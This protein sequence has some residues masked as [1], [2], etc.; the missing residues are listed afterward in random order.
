MKNIEIKSIKEGQSR[1]PKKQKNVFLEETQNPQKKRGICGIVI[2]TILI[3]FVIG[4]IAGILSDKFLA[5]YLE[6]IPQLRDYV[7][8]N[9]DG[10]IAIKREE[11]V[12]ITED[13]AIIDVVKQ[14]SP[15]VI[16]II[17]SKN[18]YDFFGTPYEQKSGGTGFIIT[19][20]GLIITNKHVV[21][22]QYA[23]YTVLTHNGQNFPTEILSLDPLTD[24]AIL[25]I[26]ADNLP[27]VTLGYSD[28]LQV[29]QKAVAIGNALGEYQNTVTVGVI[30][31]LDRVITA[32]GLSGYERLEGVIQTDAAINPGNSGGPLINISGE[33][34]G[35]N[36]AIDYQG[37]TIGF[38]IPVDFIRPA[39]DS[40]IKEGKIVRPFLGVRY[41]PITKEF[42]SLN[43]LQVDKGVLIY[44]ADK[45]Y[46]SVIYGSPAAKAGIKQNDIIIKMNNEEIDQ[47][48]SLSTLLQKYKPGD[49]ITLTVL[50][51]GKEK[52]VEVKLSEFEA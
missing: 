11:K 30:S 8:R 17:S 10:D 48:H 29:G 44:S 25:K 22:D 31:A 21:S 47:N 9:E 50:S 28:Q 15:S 1:P 35:I 24:L 41:V 38:A 14:V 34:I 5:P 19:S 26:E 42:A 23:Q 18:V 45:K 51:D 40:V 43:N 20:D 49:K 6:Q 46:S 36:T 52:N 4:S 33:V 7:K 32:S 13:S 3:S 12:E 39:I 27:V 2:L 16:S 37:Q